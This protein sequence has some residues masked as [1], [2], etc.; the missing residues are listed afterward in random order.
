MHRV[1]VYGTEAKGI[2]AGFCPSR[3]S[4]APISLDGGETESI[5]DLYE[6]FAGHPPDLLLADISRSFDGLPIRHLRK[7]FRE[8]WGDKVPLPPC[9][10][11]VNSRQME[12]PELATLVEDFALPPFNCEEIKARLTHLL[13]RYRRVASSNRVR[14]ADIELDLD[15]AIATNSNGCRIPLTPKEFALLSFLCSHR[16]KYFSREVLLGVVWGVQFD[17]GERTVDIHVRRIRAKLPPKAGS[18]LET[19]RGLGYGL[20]NSDS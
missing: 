1:L 20:R 10:A 8:I 19:R 11:L 7:M 18:F 9:L 17:G 12:S 3:Y 16:G 4:I 2:V 5:L 6:A 14:Y 15:L 13:Y